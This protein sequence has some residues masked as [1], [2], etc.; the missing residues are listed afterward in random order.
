MGKLDTCIRVFISCS[1]YDHHANLSSMYS[2]QWR[3]CSSARCEAYLATS[4]IPA[5]PQVII[6]SRSLFSVASLAASRMMEEIYSGQPELI[7][8]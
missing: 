7:C 5:G 6:A 1:E 4:I 3:S 2:T 8:C